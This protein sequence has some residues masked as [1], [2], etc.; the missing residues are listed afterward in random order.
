MLKYGDEECEHQKSMHKTLF[1][2]VMSLF[3]GMAIGALLT[4]NVM[5]VGDPNLSRKEELNSLT[6]ADTNPFSVNML[7]AGFFPVVFLEGSEY[8]REVGGFVSLITL[9][10]NSHFNQHFGA[11]LESSRSLE[12]EDTEPESTP[13]ISC[14]NVSYELPPSFNTRE[15]NYTKIENLW[16]P[17]DLSKITFNFSATTTTEFKKSPRVVFYS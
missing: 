4:F 13:L 11:A 17:E 14:T 16:C 12:E 15:N 2:T 8:V 10:N 1:G 7:E 9:P 3:F 5:Q 6:T